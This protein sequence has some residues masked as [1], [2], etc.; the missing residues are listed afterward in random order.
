ME[1]SEKDKYLKL[2]DTLGEKVIGQSKAISIISDAI[3]RNKSGISDIN[4]PLG[5]FIFAGP[6]GVGKTL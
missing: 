3:R 2:E 4:K 1:Q 5:S 6:T